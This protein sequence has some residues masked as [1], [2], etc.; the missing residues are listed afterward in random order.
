[1]RRLGAQATVDLPGGIHRWLP[2]RIFMLVSALYH[3]PLGLSGLVYDQTF[4]IG[5]GAAERAG[6]E[7]IFGVF[8]TN[9]WHSL[10]AVLLGVVSLYFTLRPR[11]ARPAALA[12][13][14]QHVFLVIAFI[15]WPSETFW[16]AS[17][18]ADQVVHSFTAIVG[19]GSALL[20]R[21]GQGVEPAVGRG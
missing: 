12:I 8:E 1:M 11:G 16:M 5:S 2:A 17:N 6:S 20:T 9:G 19:I 3:L 21:D 10:A 14:V 18:N 15:V 13:G 4:P 7:M